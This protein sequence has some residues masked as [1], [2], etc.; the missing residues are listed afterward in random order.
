MLRERCVKGSSGEMDN[1]TLIVHVCLE[2]TYILYYI[3]TKLPDTLPLTPHPSHLT[4]HTSHLT[5]HTYTLPLT[6]HTSHLTHTPHPSRLTYH[7]SPLTPHLSPLTSH[8]SHL[9]HHT[10]HIT[11]HLS[12]LTPHTW[13]LTSH[14]SHL[15]PHT[16]ITLTRLTTCCTISL[17]LTLIQLNANHALPKNT[18]NTA[19]SANF[20]LII[21]LSEWETCYVLIHNRFIS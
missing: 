5:L 4:P 8:T 11:P 21:I 14:T 17:I 16:W 20:N 1:W 3:T 19:N 13:H 18:N 15:T 2:L 7:T 12:H 6:Y 9:T 10:S